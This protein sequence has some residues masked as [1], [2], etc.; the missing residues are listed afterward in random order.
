MTN[1]AS[2]L[3]GMHIVVMSSLKSR[4]PCPCQN[5]PHLDDIDVALGVSDGGRGGRRGRR[6][7][8]GG[9]EED[10]RVGEGEGGGAKR[11]GG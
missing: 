11:R 7:A 9:G 10:A 8:T 6:V 4:N 3:D 2:H 5:V 1:L